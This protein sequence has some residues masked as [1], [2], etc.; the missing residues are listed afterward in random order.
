MKLVKLVLIG[1][2]TTMLRAILQAFIPTGHQTV[3]APSKFVS[4]GS[5]PI[6]FVVYGTVAYTAIAVIFLIINKNMS[7]SRIAKGLKFGISCALLWSIYLMEPLPH[8][9][10]IDRITYP[11]ADS[12]ALIALGLLSGKL[13]AVS[14]PGKRYKFTKYSLLNVGIITVLFFAG[15]M[16]Q[17]KIFNIYSSFNKSPV[18]SLVWVIAAGVII[19]LIFDYL[20]SSIGSESMIFKSFMFGVVIFGVDLIAFNFFMPIVFNADILD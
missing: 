19:G 10:A 5:M 7:G 17:Y 16:I 12:L 9:A 3:L 4:N 6:A 15:R 8:V 2:I 14:S 13:I 18:S 11:A 1:L 20:N